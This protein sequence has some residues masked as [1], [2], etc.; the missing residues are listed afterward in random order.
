MHATRRQ[1]LAR[2][3]G[4]LL[5]VLA[6]PHLFGSPD[7]VARAQ[8]IPGSPSFRGAAGKSIQG[9]V[10]LTT[11]MAVLRAQ[12]NGTQNFGVTLFLPDAGVPLQQSV[13]TDAYTDSSLVYN[14][15]G[16]I[17]GG[18]VAMIGTPGD[19]YLAVDASGAFQ[20]SVEQPVPGNVTTVQQTTFSGRG[21][22]VT[23]YFTLPAG[24][25]VLSV[26][27]SGAQFRGW[28]YHL[29]DLGGAPLPDGINVYDGRF[30]DFTFPGNQASY[31]VYLPDAGPYLLVT[32]NISPTDTWT[33]AFQ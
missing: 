10:S 11:G 28:L 1:F 33:F 25:S 12:H 2:T 3:G 19:H 24:L 7:H 17:K 22:D 9:P 32:D 5:A 18:A 6:A 21:K 20:I 16:A 15:I 30:F 27:T 8:A 29:D 4:S 13:D 14:E 23:P 26:Q 31:P